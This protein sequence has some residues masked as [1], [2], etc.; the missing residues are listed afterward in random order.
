MKWKNCITK[1][2]DFRLYYWTNF[3]DEENH[4]QSDLI[5]IHFYN[6]IFRSWMPQSFMGT[7]GSV[8]CAGPQTSLGP[9]GALSSQVEAQHPLP[10]QSSISASG[11]LGAYVPHYQDQVLLFELH[12]IFVFV[13]D[14]VYSFSLIRRAINSLMLCWGCMRFWIFEV[15]IWLLLMVGYFGFFYENFCFYIKNLKWKNLIYIFF[16]LFFYS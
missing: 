9:A 3:F 1:I 16:W 6:V 12:S 13:Y 8:T 2:H 15:G 11:A 5:I 4:F 10:P 14:C 7:Y